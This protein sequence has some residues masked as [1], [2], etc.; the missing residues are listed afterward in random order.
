MRPANLSGADGGTRSRRARRP[1]VTG[2]TD[3]PATRSRRFEQC[4]K[5]LAT[6]VLGAWNEV[7]GYAYIVKID[8]LKMASAGAS[9]IQ[10]YIVTIWNPRFVMYRL[11]IDK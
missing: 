5:P 1:A 10:R 4:A 3:P 11:S 7:S 8:I 9:Q 6:L 2:P